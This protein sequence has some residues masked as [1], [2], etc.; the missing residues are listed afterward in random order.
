MTEDIRRTIGVDVGDKHTHVFVIEADGEV[1]EQTRI[2]TTPASVERFF[3]R[4]PPSRVAME[5]G[6]HSRWMSQAILQLGHEVLVA[7]PR[8]LR[9]IFEN[10]KKTDRADAQILAEMARVRPALLHP[11]RH[12]GPAAQQAVSLIRARDS[13]VRARTLLVNHVRGVSKAFGARLPKCATGSLP[14]HQA[15][16]PEAVQQILA[17]LMRVVEELTTQIR[18]YEW[19][20]EQTARAS[21]PETEPLR[22]VPGVGALTALAFVA[23][24]EDPNRFPSSRKV[25]SYL[26]LRPRLDS[27]GTLQKQLGIS[28]SGDPYLRRLLVGSAQYILGPFGPDCDLRRWGLKLGQR[29]SKNAKKRAAVAVA[30]KLAVLLHALWRSQQP[31]QRLLE[32][33]ARPTTQAPSESVSTALPSAATTS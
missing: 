15:E 29:G 2:P 25:G 10:D 9:A 20:V 33:G 19:Q 8:K 4:Q 30:R 12:R 6:G 18:R 21:F 3:R 14:K 16:L 22:Q 13:L 11:I 32:T 24:L 17:P 7:N 5:V 27:S 26:G 31:Y 1:S 23:S 28:K